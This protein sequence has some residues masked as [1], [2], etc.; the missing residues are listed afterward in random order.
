MSAYLDPLHAQ[1]Q[2]QLNA[3]I[4]T[5]AS[6]NAQLAEELKQQRVEIERLVNVIELLVKDLDESVQGLDSERGVNDLSTEATEAETLLT[7]K[8]AGG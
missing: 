5:V 7:A 3:K 6:Q 8:N 4:Q 1:Q 2:N